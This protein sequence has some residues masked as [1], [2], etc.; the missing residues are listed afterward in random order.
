M[1]VYEKKTDYKA[2]M[3]SIAKQAGRFPR[4]HLV[5]FD[6]VTGVDLR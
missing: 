1:P 2:R 3:R 5:F 6:E 4:R